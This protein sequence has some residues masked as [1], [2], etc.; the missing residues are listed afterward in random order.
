MA[1]TTNKTLLEQVRNGDEVSWKAFYELYRPLILLR[2]KDLGLTESEKEELVQIVMTE[3]FRKAILTTY[4]CNKLPEN[5][6][7]KY[8]LKYGRFRHFLRRI[9][10]NHALKIIR[11]RPINQVELK[12][13]AGV[14]DCR[15]DDLWEREWQEHL[16]RCGLAE[17]RKRVEPITYQVFES[18]AIRGRRAQQVAELY[19]VSLNSVYTAKSRCTDL[20]HSLIKEIDD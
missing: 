20:L 15:S 11:S 17:L 10:T 2:G 12:N 8:D 3:I 14:S 7:F 19:G 6:A 1:F 9:I 13:A 5:L 16:L 4:D 18:Y